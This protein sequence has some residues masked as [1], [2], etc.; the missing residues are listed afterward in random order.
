MNFGLELCPSKPEGLKLLGRQQAEV[1]DAFPSVAFIVIAPYDN[2]GCACPACKP[3]GCNGFLRASEQLAKLYHRRSPQGEVLLFTWLFD[4]Q[5]MKGNSG[6]LPVHSGKSATWFNGIMAGTHGNGI[7]KE[8]LDRPSP[9]DILSLL[10]PRFRCIRPFRMAATARIHC[11]TPAPIS[12]RTCVGMSWAD[13]PTPRESSRTSTSS[14][15]RS[16]TGMP[17]DRR[18]KSW[19]NTRRTIWVRIR[20]RRG[21]L[22]PSVGE[23]ASEV[24]WKIVQTS[25]EA[26]E[27]WALAQAI[28]GR[29]APWAKTSW[30]WRILYIRRRHRPCAEDPRRVKPRGPS[31]SKP[32]VEELGSIYHVTPATHW[33]SAGVVSQT[34]F[35]H[36]GTV[37]ILVSAKMG[38]SPSRLVGERGSGKTPLLRFSTCER[39]LFG[40][41][42]RGFAR[43]LAGTV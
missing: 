16:S 28:D 40:R 24:N 6:I 32:L 13:S 42:L 41:Q 11:P 10:F 8:L 27:A 5:R 34:V 38:L 30:R 3:W 18:T 12:R 43:F 23:D 21:P 1:L 14:F 17:I 4:F 2:G 36:T 26:D 22:V 7:P 37:P 25:N 39:L 35:V 20:R 33:G 9:S 19:P 29:L 31:G 15:G